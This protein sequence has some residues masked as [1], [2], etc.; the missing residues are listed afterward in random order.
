MEILHRSVC[1][2]AVTMP[3]E[4]TSTGHSQLT[5]LCSFLASS[6]QAAW[7]VSML[8]LT[9]C[10]VDFTVQISCV[11]VTT[12][13]AS[14]CRLIVRALVQS[15]HR[16]VMTRAQLKSLEVMLRSKA[17]ELVKLS[18]DHWWESALLML[19]KQVTMGKAVRRFPGL[20]HAEASVFCTGPSI[21]FR[22]FVFTSSWTSSMAACRVACRFG[23]ASKNEDSLSTVPIMLRTLVI[24][25]DNSQV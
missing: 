19:S 20:L 3:L 16:L 25:V 17:L 18:V 22:L 11:A 24:F 2:H 9:S 12:S 23:C 6:N 15:R 7:Y 21:S 8:S 1:W 5:H 14:A 10:R 4:T 13:P